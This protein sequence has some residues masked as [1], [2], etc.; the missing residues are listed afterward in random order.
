M[1]E[2]Q[3]LEVICEL[4]KNSRQSDRAIAESL[5]ISQ[6]TVTRA[7]GALE[8]KGYINEYTLVP[9]FPKV[10]YEI[11]AISLLKTKEFLSVEEQKKRMQRA[12]DWMTQQPN[13]TFGAMSEGMGKTAVMISFHKT[14]SEYIEFTRKYAFE[15][16]DVLESH[17]AVLVNLNGDAVL[18]NFSFACLSNAVKEEKKR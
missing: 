8:K 14:F 17:D 13:V 2:T 9:N 5:G 16:S 6:P 7:R 15:A 11:M 1:K 18:K 10:G 12:K 4:M 3:L